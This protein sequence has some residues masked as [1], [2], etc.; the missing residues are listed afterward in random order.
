MVNVHSIRFTEV[1]DIR[2]NLSAIESNRDVPFE[3]KRIYY[4][5]G[6]P[7]GIDR[8][9]HSHYNLQQVLLCLNGSVTIR[10]ESDVLESH[11]LSDPADG[12][13]IGPM[14]WRE[15]AEFSDQAVLLVLASEYYNESDYIR[16][17]NV[18]RSEAD[19]YLKDLREREE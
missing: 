1:S 6:V 9:F 19:K 11:V 13:Y 16:D 12:L 4:I 2:G 5:T 17:Y 15:M 10:V 8:G 18:F 14:V 3:L 7:Q